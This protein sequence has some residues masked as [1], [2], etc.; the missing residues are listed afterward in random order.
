MKKEL[1]E[2]STEIEDVLIGL[3]KANAAT[4]IL[5]EAQYQNCNDGKFS[6]LEEMTDALYLVHDRV[7]DETSKLES[8]NEKLFA[9]AS[10]VKV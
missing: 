3:G 2:L 4:S 7:R 8:I 1:W 5:I 9:C 6:S 10:G